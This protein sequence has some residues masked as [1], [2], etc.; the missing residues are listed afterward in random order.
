MKESQSDLEER[1]QRIRTKLSSRSYSVKERREMRE[2][3]A[4]EVK[5]RRTQGEEEM[6]MQVKRTRGWDLRHK[7]G[8]GLGKGTSGA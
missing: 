7:M 2:V 1:N 8:T 5:L 4:G 3:D 6:L